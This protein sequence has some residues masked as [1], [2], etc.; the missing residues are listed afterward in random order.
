MTSWPRFQASSTN[1][2]V[3]VGYVVE[4]SEFLGLVAPSSWYFSRAVGLCI[5][6]AGSDIAAMNPA[7]G[8]LRVTV[9]LRSSSAVQES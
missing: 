8:S 4:Y 9:A 1:G 2:P 3:P 7:K 5:E 6:N